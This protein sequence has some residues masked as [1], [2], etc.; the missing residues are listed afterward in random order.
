MI[1][2]LHSGAVHDNGF[3]FL[4]MVGLDEFFGKPD[5]LLVFALEI[6]TAFIS[7]VFVFD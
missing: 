2:G 1:F 7:S 6:D 3:C 4:V 5:V